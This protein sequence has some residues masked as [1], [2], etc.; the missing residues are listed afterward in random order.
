MRKSP[1]PVDVHV[2]GRVKLRRKL[3]GMNQERLGDAVNLT[4][5]QI[6]KYERGATR[7]GGSRLYQFA[8][9]L[10]VPVS[11]FFDD[12]PADLHDLAPVVDTAVID[13]IE[14][15]EIP[16]EEVD[17]LVE[18]YYQIPGKMDRHRLRDL[19]RAF[20]GLKNPGGPRSS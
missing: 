13:Q 14:K 7:M 16:K 2:G 19:A 5:Q 18:E 11:F 1:H 10:D 9:L 3:L 8:L 12:M 17:A 6:Q 15:T 4:Y 20:A